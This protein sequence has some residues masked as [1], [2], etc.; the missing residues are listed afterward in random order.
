T[1]VETDDRPEQQRRR[2]CC[3]QPFVAVTGTA[4]CDSL[5]VDARPH[6]RVIRRPRYRQSCSCPGNKPIVTAAPVPRVL[7]KSKIGVSLWVEILLDKYL[8]QRPTYRLLAALQMQGMNLALGT[9]TDGL[10]HLEPLFTP[11]YE[12]LLE[13][14]REQP[15]WHA[16]ETRW[17]VFVSR[18]GKVGHG[19][20]L[21]LCHA[22][23]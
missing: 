2:A 23:D 8:L 19:W 17:Q 11:L 13:H 4:E 9:I 1:R 15:L 18:E 20:Y 6:R 10:Q 7:P 14:S 5:E 16:D 21:W 12:A 22:A 3:G